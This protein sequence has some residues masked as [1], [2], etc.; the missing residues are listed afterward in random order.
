MTPP[1]RVRTVGERTSLGSDQE[2]A[3]AVRMV[4]ALRAELGPS[5]AASRVVTPESDTLLT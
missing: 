1:T 3:A 4:A 2:E 5:A